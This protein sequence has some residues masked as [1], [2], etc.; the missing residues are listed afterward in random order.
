MSAREST[1]TR[2]GAN[3]KEAFTTFEIV[4]GEKRRVS[5]PAYVD[6]GAIRLSENS[7]KVLERRYLRRDIQRGAAGDAGGHVLPHRPPHRGGGRGARR[8][9]GGDERESSTTC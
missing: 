2:N 4:K 6:D 7:L 5:G 9:R 8:R 1:V 3:S